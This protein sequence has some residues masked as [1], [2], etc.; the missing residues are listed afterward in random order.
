MW[1]CKV[2]HQA[3]DICKGIGGVNNEKRYA[4]HAGSER[5]WLT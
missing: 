2:L 5:P 4:E 3:L 1:G